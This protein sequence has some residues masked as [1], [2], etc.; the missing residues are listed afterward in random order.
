MDASNIINLGI[1]AVAVIAAAIAA[2]QVAE[3]RKARADAQ[4]ARDDAAK[5]EQEALKAARDAAQSASRSA[6]AHDRIASAAEAQLELSRAESSPPWRI[7]QL[8]DTRWSITNATGQNIDFFVLGCEPDVIERKGFE[9]DKPRN[10]AVNESLIFNFGGW[11]GAPDSVN[12]KVGWRDA[13][14][15]PREY[16]ETIIRV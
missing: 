12:L 3:A 15:K 11:W 2:L 7:L 14:G 10:V 16:F 6:E 1:L 13:E 5:H 8:N 9:A 4:T